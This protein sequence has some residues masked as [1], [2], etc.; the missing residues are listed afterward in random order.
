MM[1]KHIYACAILQFLE[2]E[3]LQYVFFHSCFTLI[4]IS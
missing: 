3:I 4:L 1:D 2:A